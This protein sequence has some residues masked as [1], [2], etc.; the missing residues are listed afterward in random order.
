MLLI[1]H[2]IATVNMSYGPINFRITVVKSYYRDEITD[3]SVVSL[4]ITNSLD[5]KDRDNDSDYNS[6]ADIIV[7]RDRERSKDF[8]NKPKIT[9]A[10]TDRL[11]TEIFLSAKEEQ[12]RKLSLTL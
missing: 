2:I 6:T 7:K 11:T 10:A 12:D 3:V 4:T 1:D 8:K 5:I 9:S